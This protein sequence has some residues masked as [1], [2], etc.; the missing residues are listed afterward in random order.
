MELCIK[1][2]NKAKSCE[3]RIG[4]L[5][6]Y[7]KSENYGG[8]L[9][10]YALCRVL[11]DMGCDA[12]QI[13]YESKCS[14]F[15]MEAA[16]SKPC[17]LSPSAGA[18]HILGRQIKRA[19]RYITR[20]YEEKRHSVRENRRSAFGEFN[21]NVIPH[22]DRVYTPETIGECV[23]DYDAFITG[24]DQ[25]WNLNWYEPSYFLAF[26]PSDKLKLS[27]GASLGIKALTPV[28]KERV[29]EHLRDF[30][31]VS[32]REKDGVSV[33]DEL[34]PV[35]TE[36]VLDP[37]LLLSAEQWDEIAGERSINEKYVF[38]YFLG[39]DKC[40]RR[41]AAKYAA[42][43]GLK[44]VN[45]PHSG[46]AFIMSD[47]GFGDIRLYSVS[48][49]RFLELIKN[50]EYVFTDSFHATVFSNIYEKNFFVFQRAGMK[51][52]E[53]R[54]YSLLELFGCQERFCD[55]EAK[56]NVDYL[57]GLSDIDFSKPQTLFEEKKEQSLNFLRE[58]LSNR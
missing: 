17:S 5:T 13:S 56:R 15:G 41:I 49:N 33:I 50:A 32:V 46:G 54:I 24:S 34:S 30:N 51:Y 42:R 12:Y 18:K 47:V 11:S 31:A 53:S 36:W 39:D 27:Y 6:H 38:C 57:E 20:K 44:V 22:S 45:I 37:T 40:I 2:L 9:Q 48:P 29:R 28:Q 19:V 43:R 10:A 52:M 21:K 26:V 7:Y 23:G 58:N 3:M 8:N 25:V 35:E 14:A 16:E 4:I 55:V 1:F